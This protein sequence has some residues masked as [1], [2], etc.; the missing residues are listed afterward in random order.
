MSYSGLLINTSDIVR[1]EFDK[2]GD[3]ESIAI[4]TGRPC[5]IMYETRIMTDYKGE[6]VRSFAKIF[7]GPDE[8][9]QHKDQIKF[10]GIEH[11]IIVIRKPQDSQ[12]THHQEIWVK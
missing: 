4:Q 5:R 12:Q 6:E 3:E 2:W 7:Y 10:D 8:D 9:I 1:R 11:A